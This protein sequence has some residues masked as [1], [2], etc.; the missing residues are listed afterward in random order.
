MN[1][2]KPFIFRPIGTTLL[3]IGLAIAGMIAFNLLPV[4]PLPQIDF[5]TISVGASLPG[6][7][8]EI[9]ATSV[10]AP[11]ERQLGKI[12]GVE[13]LT[14]SS[15]LGTAR[16]T[17]QFDLSRNIDSAAREVQAAINTALAQLPVNLRTNPTY[18]K[19]NPADAPIMVIAL[20]S[21]MFSTGTMYDAA[22]TLLQQKLSQV[23]G[24]GQVIVSGSSL[25]AIR[26]ELNPNLLNQYG[27]DLEQ[28]RCA[29]IAENIN[30][31]KGYLV[32]QKTISTLYSNDQLLNASDYAS[33]IIAYHQGAPL[34]IRDVGYAIKSTEDL[35]NAGL[36]NSKPA[37]LLIL[38][39]ET[40]A[41][42]IQ[43]VE[44]VN[45]EIPY[46]KELIPAGIDLRVINERTT[47]IKASLREVELTLIIALVLVILVVYLFLN[48]LRA[49]LIP[50]VAI[51]LS[52]LGTFAC[53]YLLGFSLNNLSLM[54]LTIST[55]F[56]VDDAIVV[57]ENIERHLELGMRPI[58]AALQGI[59]EVSFTVVSMS[60]SLIAVFIPVLLMQ[61][62]V[63]R[64]FHEFAYTLA[65]AILVSLV[66]SLTLTPVMCAYLL[67]KQFAVDTKGVRKKHNSFFKNLFNRLYVFYEKSLRWVLKHPRFMLSV[68]LITILLNIYLYIVVPK[69]FF[70]L[71]D[72]GR[73]MASIQAD[74][75]VSFTAMQAKLNQYVHIVK[76]DPAVENVAGFVGGGNANNSGNVYISLKPLSERKLPVLTIIERLRNAVAK[77]QGAKLIMQPMQDLVIGG[78]MGNA[79][80]QYTITG[81]QLRDVNYWTLQAANKIAK[82]PGIA[83]VNTDQNNHSLQLFVAIDRDSAARFGVTQQAID[84]AL[85]NAFGQR[86][87]STIYTAMNQYRVVMEVAPEYWQSPAALNSVYVKSVSGKLVPLS[88]FANFSASTMPTVINHQSQLPAATLSFNLLLNY[89]LGDSIVAINRAIAE[90]HLPATVQAS[91]QGTAKAFKASLDNQPYLILT[92][93]IAIYIVLGILYESLIHPL[94]ILSTLPSA[95]VGALLALFMTGNDLNIIA[96]IGIIL[97]IGIVKKNAIMMI[98]FALDIERQ[99]KRLPV[100][101]IYNAALLRFRPIMMTTLAAMLGALPLALDY[102]IGG[103]LRRPLGITIIGGLILSQLLTLYSTPVIY[104]E[105]EKLG[106]WCKQKLMA[107][108]TFSI[109]K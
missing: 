27:V 61:G 36:A 21:D 100:D 93:L 33:L 39:K 54:A 46:L 14:S 109:S 55:G 10:T 7:N 48:N 44:R 108:K 3:A 34:R 79:Q 87:I 13:Q 98:D 5:P 62:I 78:R 24:V 103:E 6:A 52:L 82:I 4:A 57:L 90:L 11:L 30:Q 94:T 80:F 41:N 40:G 23:E 69:G 31:P 20:T 72:T 47:T 58:R 56:V 9:V 70:P 51:V 50:G 28:I 22:S 77:V 17:L 66:V 85:Y 75:T 43:T 101:A 67:K 84:S 15:N 91:F 12:A 89:S 2:A 92:A 35:R 88:A 107:Y 95:G 26:L 71:Q 76:S 42:I 59:K 29:I 25:P 65:I 73:I 74:Q 96:L 106:Q 97:L 105:L 83:D 49:M 86:Q 60:F 37:V 19:I 38:F 53:M 32:N 102:G 16:I 63:G 45:Q 8:P 99:Q 104:L 18:R 64:L 68:T 81:N 1:I